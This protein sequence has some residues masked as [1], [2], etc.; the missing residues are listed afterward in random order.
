MPHDSDSAVQREAEIE[1]LDGIGGRLGKRL[2]KQRLD[3]PGGAWVE[4]DGV[5]SD[6]S[7][8]VEAFAHQGPM[9]GGQK[10][11]VALDV[12]KLITLRRVYPDAELVLAFSDE[13]AMNS[14]T[15][16][17]AEAIEAWMIHRMVAPLDADLRS[18]LVKVQARQY[19]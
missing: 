9:K 14:V 1:I 3:L 8:L 17:M 13:A 6:L 5:A 11:K 10:R 4:V 15:G 2:S 19:R 7:V 18:R 12:L 16:W